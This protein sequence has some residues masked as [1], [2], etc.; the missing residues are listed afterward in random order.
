MASKKRFV[1]SVVFFPWSEWSR[2]LR[3]GWRCFGM[4][5]SRSVAS[6]QARVMR[7]RSKVASG[8]GQ[9]RTGA[10][11]GG[12]RLA[13]PPGWH[14]RRAIVR[15]PQAAVVC[16]LPHRALGSLGGT[17]QLAALLAVEV[18]RAEATTEEEHAMPSAHSRRHA[19]LA[20]TTS[21]PPRGID[22]LAPDCQLGVLLQAVARARRGLARHEHRSAQQRVRRIVVAPC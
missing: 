15:M 13:P 11:L 2:P 10:L 19:I 17:R 8:A 1:P 3:F 7:R 4:C 22:A 14:D 18:R 16:R 5:L 21:L 12:L 9:L 6:L 20:T